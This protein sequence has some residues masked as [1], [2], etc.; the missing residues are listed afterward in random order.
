MTWFKHLSS[1]FVLR[2]VVMPCLLF[3]CSRIEIIYK[4]APREMANRADDAFDF[5]RDR[6]K[7]VRVAIETDF[8]NNKTEIVTELSKMIEMIQAQTR[9]KTLTEKNL[10]EDLLA[11]KEMQKKIV[12]LFNKSFSSIIVGMNSVEQKSVIE[13][14]TNKR[15]ER[16]E[17]LSRRDDFVDDSFEKFQKVFVIFFDSVNPEQKTAFKNY[18]FKNYEY[19]QFQL[20]VRDDFIRRFQTDLSPKSLITL[21]EHILKFYSGDALVR[22]QAHQS[23]AQV[24]EVEMVGLMLKLWQLSTP[25]QKEF[26]KERLITLSQDLQKIE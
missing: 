12:N 3:S 20:Q 19:F 16:H 10:Q 22:S 5:K 9:D 11:F 26:F 17:L 23:K 1:A 13:Y 4:L 25:Q 7:A 15:Q 8:K 6:Y 14:L 2:L 24:F 18:I 21:K